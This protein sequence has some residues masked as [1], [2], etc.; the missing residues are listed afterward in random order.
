MK[1]KNLT[2]VLLIVLFALPLGA[3]G[4]RDPLTPIEVEQLREQTQEPAKRLKLFVQFAKARLVA[5]DQ[6]R[7]DPKLTRDRGKQLHDLLEDFDAIATELGDNL[8]MFE[9]QRNDM[10]KP[11]KEVIEGYTDWQLRLRS[12]KESYSSDPKLTDEYKQF[13]FVLQ[14]AIDTVNTGL[15][16]AR[17][18][19]DT[20][21]K[22]AEE[23]KKKK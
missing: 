22:K 23:D 8:D 9:R 7:G 14:S 15:D 5:I 16:D 19:L 12:I 21:T 10:R 11:L 4:K 3:K 1:M 17:E 2:A 20:Q 13:D 6:L 18:L